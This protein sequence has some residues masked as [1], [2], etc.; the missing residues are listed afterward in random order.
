VEAGGGG[1]SSTRFFD[2]VDTDLSGLRLDAGDEDRQLLDKLVSI[3]QI[4]VDA[5]NYHDDRTPQRVIDGLIKGY[6]ATME[7]ATAAR[8]PSVHAAAL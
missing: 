2:N 4:A 1:T 7:L 3:Q 6:S 8:S 5:L